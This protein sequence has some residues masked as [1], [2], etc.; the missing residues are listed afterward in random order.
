[1]TAQNEHSSKYL[2]KRV[3][4]ASSKAH[5]DIR[6]VFLPRLTPSK[7]ALRWP[8]LWDLAACIVWQMLLQDTEL[9]KLRSSL[10]GAPLRSLLAHL[11]PTIPASAL[12]CVKFDLP[13]HGHTWSVFSTD[14]SQENKCFS[15]NVFLYGLK[16]PK[17]VCQ[18]WHM[19]LC[20]RS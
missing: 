5:T 14:L 15:E 1:M 12:F 17:F 10:G 2:W 6:T 4:S 7:P 13:P 16:N 11:L 3:M 18:A 20:G 9:E 8:P 19:L